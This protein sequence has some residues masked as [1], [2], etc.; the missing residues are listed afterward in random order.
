M[1]GNVSGDVLTGTINGTVKISG[2]L[3]A[4]GIDGVSPTIDV[5]HIDGG[6]KL[7][8]TDVNGTKTATIKDGTTGK[9]A[10]QYAVDNGY[11][12]TEAEFA[13]KLAE[14]IPKALEVMVEFDGSAVEPGADFPVTCDVSHSQIQAAHESGA[15]IICAFYD[16]S[17]YD[18]IVAPIIP[19][20]SGSW[21]YTCGT[22]TQYRYF[23]RFTP[24][25]AY[26]TCEAYG[27]SGEDGFSP[28]ANVK[29]T[30]EGAEITIT[31]K[32]GTTK[33]TVYNGKDGSDGDDGYS[34]TVST[35]KSGKVTTISITDKNGTK[36]AKINDGVDGTN[37]TNG[38]SATHSWNG[39]T[40]TIT[41]ASG[42]SSANLK[43][44]KGDSI[45]GDPGAD[46]VSP[47]VAV[48]KSGKVTT[49]SIT[50]KNGTKTATINDGSDGASG[51]NGKDGTSVTV[52]SVS[53]S[54]ADGGSNVVTFSDGK[55]VTIKNGKT[56]TN[57]SN[58]AAGK[59]AYQYAKDGG[60][61]G[62]EAEFATK[63]AEEY[64]KP[65]VVNV[66]LDGDAVAAAGSDVQVNY[67]VPHFKI[68]AEHEKGATIIC[69]FYDEATWDELV[70]PL[71]AYN[72]DEN[73]FY[74]TGVGSKYRYF[75]RI[76]P[77]G[78]YANCETLSTGGGDGVTSWNDLT[79]K[80]EGVGYTFPTNPVF[81]GNL[82]GREAF[83]MGNNMWFVKMSSYAPTE[84][85]CYG[86]TI[87]RYMGGTTI[88]ITVQE[89]NIADASE[90][91]G[92][93][94]FLVV[95]VSD[96]VLPLIG[97]VKTDSTCMGTDVP[98]GTYYVYY[99]FQDFNVWYVK[100]FSVLEGK[101]EVH[102]IDP[103]FLPDGIGYMTVGDI[104]PE[105]EL[106][107]ES[108]IGAFLIPDF[109]PVAGRNYEI[110]YN[111]AK[112]KCAAA[113]VT[114]PDYGDCI[115]I[116]NFAAVGGVNTGEPF[117]IG[118]V[119][120]AGMCACI[121]VDEST[122]ITIRIRGEQPH[123]I[124]DEYIPDSVLT[125][126]TI[127]LTAEGFPI[128]KYNE[129]GSLTDNVGRVSADIVEQIKRNGCVNL[130]FK[131]WKT[132][133]GSGDE[134]SSLKVR[135]V[136]VIVTRNSYGKNGVIEYIDATG[137]FG[138]DT[139][140]FVRVQATSIGIDHEIDSVR[141]IVSP[142]CMQWGDG[143]YSPIVTSD[144]GKIFKLNV[145]DDGVLSATAYANYN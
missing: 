142:I 75:I 25:G 122:S 62:T 126:K 86:A 2:S 49:V 9:T 50:D 29:A 12:G 135:D 118:F 78:A 113:A 60:Y 110:T 36:T 143:N 21:F 16:S 89:Q 104:V 72:N 40:L 115:G 117:V 124:D 57:G 42:T 107:Y 48:S 67:N 111:G 53:E 88:D 81:D 93:P 63:L 22:G 109:V 80:P 4:S 140:L 70:V 120:A 144:N 68:L 69:S 136:D 52:K 131:C 6:T 90:I 17:T 139:I 112:Y 19:Y 41:S 127:D 11:T 5:E 84:E 33:A 83:Y 61:I 26:A 116:G 108:L 43:G 121:P 28:A 74:A 15:A 39:T 34:P 47:T 106:A 92:I 56:G 100:N 119:I 96:G 65:L 71:V 138:A 114:L 141:I 10:Y 23:L 14:E 123:K 51:S 82:E 20:S 87:T 54:T 24:D 38:V 91:M 58:G 1:N 132:V 37:G 3:V 59:S 8:I 30:A 45:K 99:N 64:P 66:E 31:D 46:G 27:S 130:K 103:K 7:V 101:E 79:D 35:S 97:V 77:D 133:N 128:V 145:S 134:N 13:E 137:F 44:E 105:T 18:E 55:T 32:A 129:F 98:A 94:G 76:T 85:E 102:K 95:D 125:M 73:W